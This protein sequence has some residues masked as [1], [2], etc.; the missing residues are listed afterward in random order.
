MGRN[1]PRSGAGRVAA[2]RLARREAVLL[3]RVEERLVGQPEETRG[4]GAVAGRHLQRLREQVALELLEAEAARRKLEAA[5]TRLRLAHH[6]GRQV[7]EPRAAVF[8]E[9]HQPL[10]G[11]GELAH[12]AW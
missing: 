5:A 1:L 9:Q 2:V 12:V 3:E 11:I 4:A 10:D 8:G 6:L 7:F